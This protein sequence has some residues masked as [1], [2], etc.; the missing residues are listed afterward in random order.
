VS[1]NFHIPEDIVDKLRMEA[2]KRIRFSD[3]AILSFKHYLQTCKV[4]CLPH[5][6]FRVSL[7]PVI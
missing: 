1:R 6:E 4:V 3:I 7:S 2:K 5:S